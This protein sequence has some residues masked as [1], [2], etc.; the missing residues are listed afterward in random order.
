MEYHVGHPA[1]IAE[2]GR[3][4]VSCDGV[5]IGVFRIG[6]ALK[7]WHNVCPH[8]QGPVCQGRVY[9]RVTEPLQAD[10]TTRTLAYDETRMQVACPWHGWEFDLATG[11]SQGSRMKL[12]PARLRVTEEAVYVVL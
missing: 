2:G 5:E 12:R 4:V 9:P 10:G 8:R 1:E 6:G 11:A 7:A 3:R